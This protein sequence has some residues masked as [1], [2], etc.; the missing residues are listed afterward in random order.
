MSDKLAKQVQALERQ[1]KKL[2]VQG[3]QPRRGRSASRRRRPNQSRS[4]SRKRGQSRGPPNNRANEAIV[5]G[6]EKLC[7]VKLTA[8]GT[9]AGKV[10]LSPKDDSWQGGRAKA[11]ADLFEE[12]QWM[13]CVL[14]WVPNVGTT[15]GGNVCIGI[16]W[17]AKPPDTIDSAHVMTCTPSCMTPLYQRKSLSLN[18]ARY[19]YQKW[20]R[21]H[22][23]QPI[24]AVLIYATG[25][26]GKVAG[27]ILV[28][29]SIKFQGGRLP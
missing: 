1:I 4:R 16:D 11:M 3:Q 28:D 2:Q 29:Y 25:P 23:G 15:E 14:E 8:S 18:V 19:Q 12:M 27:S 13:H 10:M 7:D 5:S 9:F 21:V 26:A 6:K 24:S 22:S 17:D 20:L